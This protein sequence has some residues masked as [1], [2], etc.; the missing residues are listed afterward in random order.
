MKNKKKLI[1][2]INENPYIKEFIEL[3]ERLNNNE[4]LKKQIVDL[5]QLQQQ[6]IN[7]KALEKWNAY[8]IV[9][10]EYTEKRRSLEENPVIKNYLNLQSEINDLLILIKEILED[11]LIIS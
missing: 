1:E 9:E 4:K 11:S 7:L 10:E 8:A 5:Q 6:M 2:A 3:E